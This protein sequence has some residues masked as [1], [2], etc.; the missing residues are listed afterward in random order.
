MHHYAVADRQR[1][2]GEGTGWIGGEEHGCL[3]HFL[4]RG[5]AAVN[6]VSQKQ[7]FDDFIL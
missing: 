7:L 6:G 1:L 2:A 5:E 3:C 4:N